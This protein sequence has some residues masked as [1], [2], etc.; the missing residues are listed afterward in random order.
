MPIVSRSLLALFSL[1]M[2][3]IAPAFAAPPPPRIDVIAYSA[4]LSEEGLA[5]AYMTL[6]A[7]SGAFERIATTTERSEVRACGLQ[8]SEACIRAVLS[9]RGTQSTG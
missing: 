7:Y 3:I 9:A 4:D 1:P 2:L 8:N 5:E 6:V